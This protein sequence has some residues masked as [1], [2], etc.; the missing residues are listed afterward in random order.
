MAIDALRLANTAFAVDMFKKLC[1]KDKTAN[2][3]F[4][5]LCTSTS[6]ALAYKATKGDTA[7]QMI[8]ALHLEDVKDVSF[9]F[10]TVTSDVSKLSS[11]LSL[12]MVKR[13]Y[14]EKS[15]NPTTE[16]IN[17]TK[18]P[19]PSELELVDFKEKT[20]ETRQQINKS[21]SEL[22][23]G[24]M[25]NILNEGSI[26]DQTK[27]LLVNTAYFVTN[28]MKKFPEAQ[29]K[30]CP[31]KINKTETKPVQMMNL[32]ATFCLGYIKELKIAI[33]ELPC[34]NKHVS[35]LILLPK[36]IEDDTTGLEQLE[37]VLTPETL[38]Q[39]TNPSV[40]ANTKVNVFLPKF[41]VEG[42]Y[43]LKS[44]LESLGMTD[45][46][47]EKVADFSE[48]SETKGVVLSQ[49]IHRVSLEVNEE[50]AELGEVPGYRIL[51][52][53][54]EFKADHPFIFLFRHNKTRNIILSGR[55]CSPSPTESCSELTYSVDKKTRSRQE[56][57]CDFTMGSISQAITEMGLDLYN[58]LN[59]NASN[60]N[61][62]FSPMSISAG[63]VMVL[64]GAR[65]N[66]ANQMQIVLHLN[67]AAGSA[68]LGTGPVPESGTTEAEPEHLNERQYH[69]LPHFPKP[70]PSGCDLVGG[71]H[72]E[73][74]TLLS[75]LKNLNKSYV[76]SLANSLFAQKGYNFHQQYLECTKELYGAMLQTVD[77]GSATE[78]ARQTINSWVESKTQGKIRELFVPGVI[79]STA[80]LVL[81]NA[82]YFKANW[83]YKFEEKHTMPRVFRINQNESKSV[84]MMY[85]KDRFKIAHIQE[86]NA[87]ILMLP[88]A[89]KSL[90]MIIL[91]PDD[92]TGLEQVERAM[93]YEKLTHWTSLESMREREVEVY[94]PRFKLEDTFE[95][96]LPLKEMGMIDVFK[97]SKA[98]LSGMAPSRQLFLSKVV[99]KAY[100]EVNEEGT[101]AAAATGS[102]V[103]NRSYPS[104]ALF[105]ADHPF[106][107]FIQHNPTNTILFL[108]KLCYP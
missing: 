60:K 70:S 10:Q 79:D 6:L 14:V 36:E 40:M 97:Q 108:G 75:Q 11:F 87:Q 88:Y 56:A 68:N 7:T 103:V 92:I 37:Q 29:L 63:L 94:L 59:K 104:G 41:K 32:E 80:V 99:H 62:F 101:L 95:L 96:N 57:S 47:S 54:D 50:G 81:V 76:L 23:D 19:F 16:F 46:F 24:K 12:K 43:D 5:P 86:M 17:A 102:V 4:A 27:I 51:Q 85:Q 42:D 67:R 58:E 93:T 69:Q 1:E 3:V 98:D 105:M 61:I 31:F 77:F 8:K 82:I 73:F 49:I 18:R 28:W 65:G 106:L 21:V 48:M 89:G 90:N 55:F 78:A 44:I 2:I 74:Q 45:I 30:E 66:T 53:K 33:L 34:L 100:V 52:H 20:E 91:L 9:G 64:L 71:I 35:M 26:N 13:L 83:E 84:Q 38:V 39:W 22:T 15:L 72:K 107:F 25:E